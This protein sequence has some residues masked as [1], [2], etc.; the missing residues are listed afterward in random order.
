VSI[1]VTLARESTIELL[2]M[3][4]T[5]LPVGTVVKDILTPNAY[6]LAVSSAT[7]DHDNV[8][9]V[10]GDSSLRWL[11]GSYPQPANIVVTAG[12]T[13]AAAKAVTVLG[14]KANATGDTLPPIG[15]T[16][17][18]AA[19]G[20]PMQITGAGI[21][22]GVLSSATPGAKYW[23]GTTAGAIT[24]TKPSASGNALWLL[25]VATSATDLLVKLS[26]LG[27]VP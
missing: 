19:S 26:Y 24:A 9:S 25:G 1:L 16:V 27:T 11:K 17:A 10:S 7:V 14:V 4:V 8:E 20:D 5:G 6:T 13:V 18:G 12:E 22:P 23:L 2:D 3:D 15:V 21:A